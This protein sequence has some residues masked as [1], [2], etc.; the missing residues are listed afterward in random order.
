MELYGSFANGLSIESSD[1]DLALKCEQN[2]INKNIVTI[3]EHFKKTNK[4]DSIIPIFTASVPVIKLVIHPYIGNRPT[5]NSQRDSSIE[6]QNNG[7]RR[8]EKIKN[9]PNLR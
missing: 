4:F 3:S 7:D 9:R 2:E 6:I 8:F 1:I 5:Q